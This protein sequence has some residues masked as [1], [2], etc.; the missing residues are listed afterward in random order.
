[1]SNVQSRVLN[2][3]VRIPIRTEFLTPT[4]EKIQIPTLCL[5]LGTLYLV[6]S[7]LYTSL[8]LQKSRNIKPIKAAFLSEY[9]L[10]FDQ[11]KVFAGFAFKKRLYLV[12][13]FRR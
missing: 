8:F 12:L 3:E 10:V 9:L 13:I 6:L 11:L 1:M 5:V 7:T 4:Y 2:F